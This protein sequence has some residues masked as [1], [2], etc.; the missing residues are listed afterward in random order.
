MNSGD[1][2]FE[3]YKTNIA[4]Q[5]AH[6]KSLLET[7]DKD[8]SVSNKK[9]IRK[10]ILDRIEIINSELD[11]DSH[12]TESEYESV[13]GDMVLFE[14][15]HQPGRIPSDLCVVGMYKEAKRHSECCVTDEMPGYTEEGCTNKDQHGIRKSRAREDLRQQVK[16]RL[17]GYKRAV[18]YFL[19]V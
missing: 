12:E 3:T 18:D 1:C 15:E 2:D 19:K 5:L 17:T 10:R 6:E 11:A 13:V 4:L 14:K 8:V 7:L 16:E 9:V